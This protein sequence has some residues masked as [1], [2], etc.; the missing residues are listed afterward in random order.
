M[1]RNN[2]VAPQEDHNG[3]L[4]DK[5]LPEDEMLMLWDGMVGKRQGTK[6]ILHHR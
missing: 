2:K 4:C 3:G 5:P 6:C 1:A